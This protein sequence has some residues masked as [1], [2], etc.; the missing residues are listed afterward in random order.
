MPSTPGAAVD[1]EQPVPP[2]PGRHSYTYFGRK[3]TPAHAPIEGPPPVVEPPRLEPQPPPPAQPPPQPSTVAPPAAQ[4]PRWQPHQPKVATPAPPG[5]LSGQGIAW[6]SAHGGSGATTLT[7]VLGGVDLGCRWPNAG[8]HEPARV[9]LVA[10]THAQ[11][12]RAASRALNAIREG[13]HPAGMELVGLVLVA[14]APGRLPRT[15]VSRIKVLRSA[16]PVHRIPW[17]APWRVGKKV[18]R[19]PRQVTKLEQR[20]QALNRGGPREG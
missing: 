10:R 15:L 17:I 18:D 2:A 14:D 1:G 12:L 11:G 20:V 13:R 16:V 8:R 6:V 3:I 4:V 7:A 19:L 9:F 5:R